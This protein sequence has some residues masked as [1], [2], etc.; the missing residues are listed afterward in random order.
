MT[1]KSIHMNT[2]LKGAIL[3]I[4]MAIGTA[5]SAQIGIPVPGHREADTQDENGNTVINCSPATG[6]CIFLLIHHQQGVTLG[7]NMGPGQIIEVVDGREVPYCTFDDASVEF[8]DPNYPER[9]SRT[10]LT[11][12]VK[13]N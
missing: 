10:T 9:G 2:T 3:L 5:G 4:F 1:A 11:N 12:V 7:P 6:V 8:V 13:I